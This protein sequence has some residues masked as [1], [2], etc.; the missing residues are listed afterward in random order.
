MS[1]DFKR[2]LELETN[3]E[4]AKLA[5]SGDKEA[6]QLLLERCE[7]LARMKAS[8][9]FVHGGD[10]EDLVQEG[11]IGLLKAIRGYRE[12]HDSSF[13][14]FA[15]LCI[16]RSIIT[17]VKLA[18]RQKHKPLLDYFS[19]DRYVGPDGEENDRRLPINCLAGPEEVFV[20]HTETK[21]MQIFLQ[22]KL[23]PFELKVAQLFIQGFTYKEI[24][25]EL[26]RSIK[27]VD[28]ALC[29]IRAKTKR[30]IAHMKAVEMEEE[31]RR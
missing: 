28:N 30:H 24:A 22:E 27:E 4:L 15:I 29:R 20:N 26:K 19:L 13:R 14:N 23:S 12:G 3:E 10:H 31:I 25:Q 17:A 8:L 1:F 7:Y 21:E 2:E 16:D 9:Y 11:L 5:Q 18:N 6:Q